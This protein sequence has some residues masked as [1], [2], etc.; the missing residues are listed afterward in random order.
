VAY[1]KAI[2]S[3]QSLERVALAFARATM[4]VDRIKI[5]MICQE[6]H[7][8]IYSGHYNKIHRPPSNCIYD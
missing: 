7:Y 6:D 8:A 1:N 4:L 5:N 2:N 3:F